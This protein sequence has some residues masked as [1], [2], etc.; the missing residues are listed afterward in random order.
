MIRYAGLPGA[1]SHFTGSE[2][3]KLSS[4]RMGGTVFREINHANIQGSKRDPISA[5]RN[6]QKIGFSSFIS[7]YFPKT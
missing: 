1:T 3:E 5:M 4:D 2:A 7:T 6:L